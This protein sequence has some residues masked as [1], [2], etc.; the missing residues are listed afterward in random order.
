MRP[1]RSQPDINQRSYLALTRLF[2]DATGGLGCCRR[3]LEQRSVGSMFSAPTLSAGNVAR[4]WRVR[5][6]KIC[7][8]PHSNL[9]LEVKSCHQNEPTTSV[10]MLPHPTSEPLETN[11]APHEKIVQSFSVAGL[12]A[13]SAHIRPPGRVN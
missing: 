11:R 1:A 12:L 8:W 4:L 2:T 3:V 5:S 7:P 9:D 13:S 10:Q 6:E